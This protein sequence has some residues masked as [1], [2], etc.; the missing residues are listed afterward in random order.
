MW[1]LICLNQICCDLHITH[2]LLIF[3]EFILRTLDVSV[4]LYLGCFSGFIPCMFHLHQ[5]LYCY[6]RYIQVGNAVAVPVA[7]ALGYSLALALK[8]LS[9]DEPVLKLPINFPKIVEVPAEVSS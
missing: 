1:I 4:A 6:F 7:R 8:G 9:G 5:M 2:L 3:A